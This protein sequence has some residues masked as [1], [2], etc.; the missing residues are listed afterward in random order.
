MRTKITCILAATILF[1]GCNETKSK[2]G[3]ETEYE[4]EVDINVGDIKSTDIIRKWFDSYNKRDLETVS[5]L[6]HNDVVLHAPNGMIIKGSENHKELAQQ[7][8]SAYPNANWK[9]LWSISTDIAF[10][11]KS[12]ENWVTTCVDVSYG[13]G[14]QA[15]N[16]QRI[17][18]AQIIDGKIKL[19]YGYERSVSETEFKQKEKIKIYDSSITSIIDVN[20]EIEELVDS[21]LVPEGP[22]WDESSNSLLFVDVLSNKLYKW[23]EE[24]GA[25]EYISPSG[26]TGYA[27]NL[28]QGVLGAN[29]LAF[30]SEGYIIACQHGDRR[31]ARIA[32]MS[33]NEPNFETIVDN[34]EGQTL[35]SPNDLT[36]AKDGA[37]YFSDPAFGFLDLDT[38]QFVDSE[39]RKLDFNGIYKYDPI[40]K[41]TELITKDIDLPNG[42]ALSNDEKTLYI[43]KYGL[44]DSNQ[45]I[46][47]VNLENNELETFFEGKELSEKYEGNF[48][49]MK[50]HSS[51][52]IFTAGPGGI[53]VISP[54]GKLKAKLDFGSITNC[55]FDTNEEY[56]Y[57][58]GFIGN[59][60]V[61][62]IKL[63]N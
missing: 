58:T 26:N 36:I 12:S 2:L 48:D 3:Y 40:T 32:N 63:K 27:P 4:K 60:K 6:E 51:G 22:V 24:N 55:A 41:K 31:I 34:F 19:V 29:G 38:F 5:S 20:A 30:D 56:L 54:E 43:N 52:N 33:S 1:L 25:S 21:L 62:R 35:N 9:V 37:I 59:E 18:D 57:V 8:L 42:L 7:F 17:I 15:T 45:K 47:K 53:L 10:E 14:E 50:V 11:T 28:G 23:N 16:I 49:G 46:M 13:E 61:Y 44:L 39:L